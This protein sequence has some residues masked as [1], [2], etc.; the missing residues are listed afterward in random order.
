MSQDSLG[1]TYEEGGEVKIVRPDFI[2]FARQADGSVA[3][4]II[5]P[6]GIQFGDALPKLR[7]LADYAEANPG[8]FRRVEVYAEID[9]KPRVIDLSEE[10]CRTAVRSA[11]TVKEAYLHSAASDYL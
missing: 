3:A 4:D 9:G 2:F 1:V 6:H 7:G 10:A 8:V 5:D 11:T